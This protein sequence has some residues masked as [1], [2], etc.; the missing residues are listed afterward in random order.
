MTFGA[1]YDLCES[2]FGKIQSIFKTSKDPTKL[3]ADTFSL[4]VTLSV[5]YPGLSPTGAK[6]KQLY[7]KGSVQTLCNKTDNNEIQMLDPETLEPIGIAT[8][9]TLHPDLK[10]PSSGTHAKSDPETGDV[11]NYN[12]EFKKGTGYYRVFRSNVST[13]KTSILAL[14]IADPAYIHSISLTK[15]YVILCV[16]NSRFSYGGASVLWTKNIVDS[17]NPYDEDIKCMW[18]IVDRRSKEEGGQGLVATYESDGFYCFHTVNSFEESTS[19]GKVDIVSDLIA[20]PNLDIIKRYYIDNLIS[21]S[22]TAATFSKDL[23]WRP[24]MR[25]FRLPAVPQK[26][27]SKSADNVLKAT[28]EHTAEWKI[29][30]ELPT[31]NPRKVLKKHRY[32]Y[33]LVHTGKSTLFDDLVKY[34]LETHTAKVWSQHGHSA[35]EAIFVPDPAAPEDDE[36]NGV[37]LTVVMNGF[38]GKSYLLVLDAKQMVEIGRANVDGAIGFGFHGTHVQSK[39]VPGVEGGAL[40]V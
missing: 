21:D 26:K 33:G 38:S 11:F 17:L 5:N 37:L 18:Y 35:S 27:G 13:G 29:S 16:W 22:P 9:S 31:I 19:D 39:L 10:G 34:D 2:F 28:S 25:R 20:Y 7:S 23:S 15:H 40:H 14:V 24:R 6:S 36:D 32:V 30:P 12:L 3:P 8:Q 1:K 4:A